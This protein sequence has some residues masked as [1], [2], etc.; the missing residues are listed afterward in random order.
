MNKIIQDRNKKVLADLSTNRVTLLDGR[1]YFDDAGNP[2]PSVTTILD[3]YPKGAAFYEWLKRNGSEADEI[4]D[5]A[6]RRGSWVH[7]V[8]ERYDKGEKIELIDENMNLQMGMSHWAM[9]TR[10]VDFTTRFSPKHEIIEQNIIS[11]RLNAAGTIDRVTFFEHL[12]K[13]YLI[14]IKTSPQI[15]NHFWIQGAAYAAMLELEMGIKVDGIAILHL[16]AKIRT[17]GKNGDIQGEG[18]KL[19][20]NPLPGAHYMELFLST[21]KLWYAE[22]G[23]MV[24][25]NIT[26]Q[27]SHQKILPKEKSK[28]SKAKRK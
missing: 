6:G 1:F 13:R 20:F 18:W 24:P 16:N 19:Y 14:D 27:L 22:N 25:K 12:G 28:T 17:E 15:Y 26:Y 2:I 8:T 10:Y 5:T 4:M 11:S 9:F 3:A 7:D 21:Q 23:S